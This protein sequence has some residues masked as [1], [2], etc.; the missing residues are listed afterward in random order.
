MRLHFYNFGSGF[1]VYTAG[2]VCVA[3]LRAWVQLLEMK[4]VV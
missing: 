3:G 4:G 1:R 2:R